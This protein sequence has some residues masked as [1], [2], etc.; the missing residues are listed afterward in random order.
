MGP[1]NNIE[2]MQ[3]CRFPGPGYL[4]DGAVAAGPALGGRS[5][6]V[7]ISGLNQFRDWARAI[8]RI[9]A[10]KCRERAAWSDL[11]DCAVV[12][13]SSARG[14]SVKIAVRSLDQQIV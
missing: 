10:V 11:E 4:K 9:E 2:A 5:I 8:L 14:C 6:E 3:C 1:V 7:A 12:M 13:D